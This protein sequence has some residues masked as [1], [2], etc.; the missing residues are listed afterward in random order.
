MLRVVLY[1]PVLKEPLHP[2]GYWGPNHGKGHGLWCK[3]PYGDLITDPLSPEEGVQQKDAL[4]GTSGSLEGKGGN[5]KGNISPL[6][7]LKGLVKAK[8]PVQGVVGVGGI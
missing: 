3:E 8:G 6:K 7:V 5:E 1:A 2:I 4:V